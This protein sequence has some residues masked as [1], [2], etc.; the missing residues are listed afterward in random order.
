MTIVVTPKGNPELVLACS[1]RTQVVEG[2][3]YFPPEVITPGV[4]SASDTR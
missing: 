3:H 1:D 2:N 4:F